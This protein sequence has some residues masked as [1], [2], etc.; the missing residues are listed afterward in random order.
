[1][2]LIFHT[3]LLF[4]ECSAN[5]SHIC[6][7]P[8]CSPHPHFCRMFCPLSWCS[9]TYTFNHSVLQ[10]PPSTLFYNVLV[11]SVLPIHTMFST[12]NTVLKGSPLECSPTF[13][14]PFWIFNV[15]PHIHCCTMFS[16]TYTVLGCIFLLCCKIS[17]SSVIFLT[18]LK[19]LPT[20]ECYRAK[21]LDHTYEPCFHTL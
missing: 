18:F 13:T 1:M 20:L 21:K 5:I 6:I 9:W 12:V 3:V 14:L 8:W 7:V 16:H 17:F 2:F 11:N 4:L 15:V 10:C 19:E